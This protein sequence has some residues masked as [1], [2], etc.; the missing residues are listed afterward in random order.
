[1]VELGALLSRDFYLRD[2]L[3]VAKELIGCRLCALNRYV[4]KG[5]FG[6]GNV[7][8]KP[9]DVCASGI[10]VETEG[11]LGFSDKACHSYKA[12]KD[13]RVNVMYGA[14][15]FAYIYLVY[16]MHLCFNAV[17]REEGA[18]EAV[19]VRALRPESAGEYIR[20]FSGPGKLCKGMGIKRE[21]YGADLC[22][23]SKT[24][25]II[26]KPVGYK[27]PQITA[28]KRIGVDYSEEAAD[29]LYRFYDADSKSVS[30][31]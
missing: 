27:P 16:G 3:T 21:D 31:R 15:G 14:G 9:E 5:E 18:P 6:G 11:Y 19:L 4:G 20:K 8:L 10:I 12:K 13:G 25:L 7:L 24:R 17:T 29:Y 28:A 23:E 30:K 2:T 22:A 1:V 26:T